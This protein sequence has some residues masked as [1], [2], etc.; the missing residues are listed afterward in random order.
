M[1]LRDDIPKLLAHINDNRP[2][3]THNQKL[4]DIYEG[5]L[6]PYIEDALRSQ[7]SEQSFEQAR[8]RISPL[9]VLI[10]LIDKLSAIYQQKPVREAMSGIGERAVPKDSE[11]LKWYELTLRI[12][13]RFNVSNEFFNLFK[14][15]LIQPYVHGGAPKMRIIPSD[16]F[17]VYS[18]DPIDPTIPTHIILF[19]GSRVE[20]IGKEEFRTVE[21][22]HIYTD[23]EF[24]IVNSDGEV[25]KKSMVALGNEDG[26]NVFGVLPF[27]YINR[28]NNL[29]IPKADT[30]TLSMTVLLPLIMSDINYAVM[31]QAF[32]I[33][34]T[35]NGKLPDNFKMAP[36]SVWP[37]EGRSD[38][39]KPE[40][41]QIKP[42]VDIDQV[43]NLIQAE[44]AFWL[45]TRGIKPGAITGAMTAQNFSSAISKM[46][47]EM[48]TTEARNKQ[49]EIYTDV[50]A[51][52]WELLLNQMHPV[53]VKGSL[54]ENRTI[55]TPTSKVITNFAEQIPMVRRGDMIKDLKE[56]VAAGFT[57][58]K[59][60][61]QRL[62]PKKNE[63]EIDEL[64]GEI[65]E[66]RG[67]VEE[68]KEI[69]EGSA[70][71]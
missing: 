14:N 49:V 43:L 18:N 10:R 51:D 7:L 57:T 61:V 17:L 16:R 25:E 66:E 35:L 46:V 31:F 69:E 52:F 55:W 54:V 22:Y 45:N 12:N 47:D 3:L 23:E 8:H 30:D 13:S 27:V 60:A 28:S 32:S 58:R 19:M 62:N 34:Y 11:L 37:I 70:N 5:N 42:Q 63:D 56:E 4:F 40:L 29:L 67:F 24:L 2:L 21:I 53:W 9:N 48:D 33:I 65:D 38:E 1:S 44:L 6:L 41:G 71:E 36:N 68:P 64:L 26:I 59:N 20:E 39:E 50:E 15:D